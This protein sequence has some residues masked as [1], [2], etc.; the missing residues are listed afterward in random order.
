MIPKLEIEL[1]NKLTAVSVTSLER[2]KH[3][4]FF[5]QARTDEK[6]AVH[7][8]PELLSRLMQ[9]HGFRPGERVEIG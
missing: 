4:T 2:N 1:A 5:I 6:G 9:K 3:V 7:I 8:N